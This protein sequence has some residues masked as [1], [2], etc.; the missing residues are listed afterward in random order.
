M[1]SLQS[2]VER[3]AGTGGQYK[4]KT[5]GERFLSRM[6]LRA[7]R[8]KYRGA[9]RRP[10]RQEGKTKDIVDVIEDTIEEVRDRGY[11]GYR[12]VDRSS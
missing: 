5:C 3:E 8:K 9:H 12:E 1:S 2:K 6:E 7:H 10:R 4:C 11:H